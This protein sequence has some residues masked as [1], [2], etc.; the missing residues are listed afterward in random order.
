MG[1]FYL[2]HVSYEGS[3]Y[4]GW[5]KQ[6][7][8]PTV[9]ET[10]FN[11]LR[12][13]YPLGRIDVKA[14]SRT[15]RGVHAFSQVVKFLAPRREDPNDVLE[16][17]NDA[18]PDDIVFHDLTR[19]N[20]SFKVTYLALYKEY[21]YFFSPQSDPLPYSFVGHWAGE[22][23]LEMEKV[24]KGAKHFEGIHN[25]FHFQYRS[26]SKGGFEREVLET[27]I[28]KAFELFPNSFSSTDE[29]YCFHVKGKGFLK[30]MVRMMVGGLFKYAS[31]IISEEE[32]IESLKGDKTAEKVSFI[33]PPGGLFLYH[34]AFPAVI[35][36]DIPRH[37]VDEKN[38]LKNDPKMEL[39]KGKE[40]GSFP[41]EV[42]TYKTNH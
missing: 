12:S 37:V 28:Y 8:L 20:K 33:A 25:F 11:S 35:V 41:I 23:P 27:N 18:L 13:I 4:Y 34:I 5:Q 24:R 19:I 22:S 21:L 38:W 7:D 40:E 39:W 6:K 30:Q 42:Y 36:S 10:I 14:T 17:L 32:L 31:G 3:N 16:K 29:V 1:K 26:D 15:D 9:Q 2:G